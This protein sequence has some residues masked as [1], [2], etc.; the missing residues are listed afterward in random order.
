MKKVA[1]SWAV[2]TK[3]RKNKGQSKDHQTK[4]KKTKGFFS[5]G[6]TFAEVCPSPKKTRTT[7]ECIERWRIASV[8]GDFSSVCRAATV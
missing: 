4:K 8:V 6:A 1:T 3:F 7:G 2:G 5:K